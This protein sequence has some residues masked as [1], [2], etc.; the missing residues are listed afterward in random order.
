VSDERVVDHTV[1]IAA[2]PETVWHFLVD[3]AGL[4]QWWGE[5][6][7]DPVAGGLLRVHMQ[8][9]PR[10]V[11][12]GEIVELVPFER[13]CSRSAGRTAPAHPGSRRAARA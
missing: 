12:R 7:I 10:P 4:A 6:E 1:R 9:G 13:L 8:E 5:A 2:R 3:P 11:M